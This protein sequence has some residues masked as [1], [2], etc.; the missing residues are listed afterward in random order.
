MFNYMQKQPT[1]SHAFKNPKTH[2][3]LKPT[4]EETLSSSSNLI[5]YLI[6]QTEANHY[7]TWR[8]VFLKLSPQFWN[9]PCTL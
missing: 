7:K 9:N 3:Y 4:F 8:H 5:E 1:N 2:H 6:S